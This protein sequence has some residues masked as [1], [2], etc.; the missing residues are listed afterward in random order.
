[1]YVP[2]W[3]S[4]WKTTQNETN[5]HQPWIV[6]KQGYVCSSLM[7]FVKDYSKRNKYTSAMDSL[8]TGV[9]MFLSDV[10]G[11]RLLKTKQIYVSHGLSTN[12]GMY[13]PL[14]CSCWKTTQNETNTHQPWIVYKQ[15]YVC[16]SLMF[17]LKDYSKWN[18]YT[19]AMDSLQTG[20][21]MF[22][23]DVLGERLLK[24]KQIHISHG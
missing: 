9:C 11:E 13:V 20:V 3:C 23:S 10:L 24:T 22:L 19:S 18:K 17:L 2:L 15:G 5:T 14:W 4:W 7:F 1:M 6:Y 21:C 12:R 8:Q 16:S